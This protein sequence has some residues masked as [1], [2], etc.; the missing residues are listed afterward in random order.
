MY[1]KKEIVESTP[2]IKGLLTLR[3]P[4]PDGYTVLDADEYL[5]IGCDLRDIVGLDKTIRS[6]S[7]PKRCLVL[8]VAEVSVTYMNSDSA[9]ALIEWAASLSSGKP[10]QIACS[11]LAPHGRAFCVV[12]WHEP[13][14]RFNLRRTP[15]CNCRTDHAD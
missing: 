4:S 2:Q 7:E 13:L 11:L 10:L 8:C 3:T 1:T 9:D 5:A 12:L 15:T 14:I 6:I